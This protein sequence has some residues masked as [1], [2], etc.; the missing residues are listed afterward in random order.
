MTFEISPYPAVQRRPQVGRRLGVKLVVAAAVLMLFAPLAQA[1]ELHQPLPS[2]ASNA[3][4]HYQRAMLFLAMVDPAQRKL[5]NKPIWEIVNAKTTAKEIAAID[6]VLI[7]SRHAI[8]TAI[9]GAS[10]LQ[11]DFGANLREYAA[12]ATLPH[13]GPMSDLAKLV[14]LH[15]IHQQAKGDM[16]QAAQLFLQVV[17]MGR[18]MQQQLTLA[19]SLEGAGIL[20]TGCHSLCAW[21]VRCDDAELINS[22]R[23]ALHAAS[24][25]RGSPS[26]A[27]GFEAS[28]LEMTLDDVQLAYPDGNWA[29]IIMQAVDAKPSASTPEAMRAAAKAAVI[30]RGVPASIF[31]DIDSFEAHIEKLRKTHAAYYRE[32]MASLNLP[33]QSAVKVG[34]QV[35][36]TFAPRLKALGDPDILNPGT[37]AAYFA[38]HE[39]ELRLANLVLAVSAQKQGGLFPKDLAAV[40]SQLGGQLP[41]NPLGTGPVVYSPTS[42]RRGF[43]IHYAGTTIAGIEL[44]EVGFQYGAGSAKR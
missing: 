9:V 5:H 19:E 2:S 26:R 23:L 1:V 42:D 40:T 10:Q 44:P 4:L 25:Q 41:A 15:G 35:Y 43:K 13:V 36:E 7:A 39:A 20:E 33:A 14:A 22:V 32:S 6:D 37:I 28:V 11:A 38:V 30:K 3:A 12:S 16:Q 31:D 8:R 34:Q 27:I 17:R 21:A 24:A 29:E 18:H